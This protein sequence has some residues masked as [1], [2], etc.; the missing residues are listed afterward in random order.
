MKLNVRVLAVSMGSVELQRVSKL[1][2]EWKPYGMPAS[3]VFN[4]LDGWDRK[5]L[6]KNLGE[7]VVFEFGFKDVDAE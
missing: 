6:A 3:F 7:V 5:F 1:N 4:H 2:G